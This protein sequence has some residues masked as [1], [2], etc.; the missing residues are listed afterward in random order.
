MSAFDAEAAQERIARLPFVS[1]V[2]VERRMPDA[3]VVHIT[4]TPAK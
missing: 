1:S 2:V 4:E 3:I